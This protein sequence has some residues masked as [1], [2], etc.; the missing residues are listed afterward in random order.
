MPF[1]IRNASQ[2]E[3][4]QHV[5]KWANQEQW[6]CVESD[7]AA[8]FSQD[9]HGF[10]IGDLEGEIICSVSAMKYGTDRGFIGFYIVI[11]KYRGQGYGLQIFNRGMNYLK[12]RN[13]ALDGV[14]AQVPNYE[15]SGFKSTWTVQRFKFQLPIH[16]H[17]KNLTNQSWISSDIKEN[18]TDLSL[19]GYIESVTKL[20]RKTELYSHFFNRKQSSG[21][22]FRS[23]DSKI[24]NGVIFAR[25]APDGY[26]IGP[27]FADSVEIAQKLIQC[28]A[29]KVK[30]MEPDSWIHVDVCTCNK[31]ALHLMNMLGAQAYFDMSH[32]WTCGPAIVESVEKLYGAFTVE[33]G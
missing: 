10:F 33:F 16:L 5:M 18:P 11:P 21:F 6:N 32:M 13:V 31:N 28:M 24:V 14:I 19:T 27:W 2:K 12:D 25:K 15:K 26:K 22:I 9:Q 20:T 30:L 7:V 1:V 4:I 17:P 29:E 23:M 8:A 3:W